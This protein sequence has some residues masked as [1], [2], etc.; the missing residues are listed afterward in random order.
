MDVVD[1]LAK[2]PD[3][4]VEVGDDKQA[5]AFLCQLGIAGAFSDE[6]SFSDVPTVQICGFDGH[7]THF[8]IAYLFSGLPR[9]DDNG[10]LVAC[11]PRGAFEPGLSTDA[12]VSGA[13]QEPGLN[14]LRI[15]FCR[16]PEPKC[17]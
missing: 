4:A 7:R 3:Q 15:V 2:D 17:N 5:K 9:P 12:L 6:C 16:R 8:I 14:G 10:Y 13:S 11:A 1:I